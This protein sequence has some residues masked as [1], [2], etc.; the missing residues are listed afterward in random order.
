[1][2]ITDELRR[3][4]ASL[5]TSETGA[6]LSAAQR[7][8]VDTIAKPGENILLIAPA[9]SGKTEVL[10]SRCERD[11]LTQIEKTDMCVITY[12]RIAVKTFNDRARERWQAPFAPAC[13]V[14]AWVKPRRLN[15]A[16]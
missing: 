15:K 9:G 12:S 11:M 10:L 2:R 7:S 3:R 1:M 8:F 4:V 14:H 16:A 6:T 13:T 5:A